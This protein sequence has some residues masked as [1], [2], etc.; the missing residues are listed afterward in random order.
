M[1]YIESAILMTFNNLAKSI[2]AH[3]HNNSS[4][5][6]DVIT[7]YDSCQCNFTI[8]DQGNF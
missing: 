7:V 8:S 2:I 1:Y 4:N 6:Y 3:A 5:Y